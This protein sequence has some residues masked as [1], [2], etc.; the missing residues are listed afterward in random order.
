M[1]RQQRRKLSK[2]GQ[3]S[4]QRDGFRPVQAKRPATIDPFDPTTMFRLKYDIKAPG[5]PLRSDHPSQIAGVIEARNEADLLRGILVRLLDTY[6]YTAHDRAVSGIV[7]EVFNPLP[8]RLRGNIAFAL[9]EGLGLSIGLDE[10]DV[11][12]D[13]KCGAVKERGIHPDPENAECTSDEPCVRTPEGGHHEDC[14]PMLDLTVHAPECHVHR[15]VDPEN[16]ARPLRPAAY[17]REEVVVVNNP[18]HYEP[19]NNKAIDPETGDVTDVVPETGGVSD[20]DVQST[21]DA[22]ESRAVNEED[23]DVGR[24]GEDA[25]IGTDGSTAA[26]DAVAE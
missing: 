20:D 17:K 9:I 5:G 3:V 11:C 23:D 15:E 14:I 13:L 1:N 7:G 26:G 16:P 8:R 4:S 24:T 22:D 18:R 25:G 10:E 2:P 12:D 6:G 21:V 19:L